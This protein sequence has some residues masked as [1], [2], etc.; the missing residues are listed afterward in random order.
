MDDSAAGKPLLTLRQRGGAFEIAGRYSFAA[1]NSGSP[2]SGGVYGGK[3][4][5]YQVGL[6][7]YP[8]TNIRFLLD[9]LIAGVD[10]K[11]SP[12]APA[13]QIPGRTNLGTS[14]QAVVFRTQ[15]NW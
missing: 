1:L 2:F 9:Y 4:S 14:F 10:R 3:Q 7:W 15:V 12:G 8:V 11:A 5:I 6:N 13:G